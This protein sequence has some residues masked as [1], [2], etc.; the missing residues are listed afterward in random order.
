MAG[1][2]SRV[3]VFAN[4]KGGVGKTTTAISLAT[5]VSSRGKKVLLIDMDPQAN[6][7]S[8]L[9]V[10]A[11]EGGS[12]YSVLLGEGHLKDLIRKT[13]FDNLHII[14]AEEDLAGA[15]IEVARGSNYLHVFRNALMPVKESAEY[16]YIFIDCPPSLGILTM[17]SL[18]AADGM[19][20]PIQCE[21]YALEGLSRIARIVEG[22]SASGANPGLMIEGIVMTMYDGRTNLARDVV[23]EVYNYF[24]EKVFQTLIPRNVRISEAPSHGMPVT[25]YDKKS[26]GAEAYSMLAEEFIERLDAH[27]VADTSP[28]E[29]PDPP[30]SHASDA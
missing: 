18:M 10:G 30:A 16:D 11:Q 15:E 26:L 5:A 24:G 3:I 9:G 22:L 25:E 13:P 6:A 1:P 20:I 29:T 8:G 27:W 17:N 4:Q 12:A 14:P 21:Y 7:S 19:V 23:T 2:T 28:A